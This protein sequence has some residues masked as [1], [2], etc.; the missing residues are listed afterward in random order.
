MQRKKRFR[1]LENHLQ[2][3]PK[4]QQPMR[5]SKASRASGS[6]WPIKAHDVPKVVKFLREVL[7]FFILVAQALQLLPW[8]DPFWFGKK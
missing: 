5:K 6:L 8:S 4:R 1:R 3:Y 7:S 2:R